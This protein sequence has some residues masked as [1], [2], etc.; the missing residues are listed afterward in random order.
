MKQDK[1]RKFLEELKVKVP[2]TQ[3]RSG[4]TV[5]ECPLG[6]WKH[7]GGKSSP[8][9]FGVK[10]EPGDPHANCFAC[11]FH[12]T[13][14]ELLTEAKHRNKAQ[15]RID[16]KW[17]LLF[18]MVDQAVLDGDLDL[19]TP[20]IEEVMS[21]RT[22]DLHEF[23]Q[24]W[25]DSF[26]PVHAIPWANTYLAERNVSPA[27]AELLDLRA[28]T[29][30]HRIC[31]PV[32]D[33]KHRLVGLHGRAV[34]A[35]V[36]PRYRMYLQA[37][38][39]NPIVWLGEDWVDL[40]RPIITVE[41]PFDL[42]SVKRVYDNVVSPLFVN[43][44]IAKLKR[45]S[46]ALEWITLYDRGAGGDAGREKVSKLLDSDHV[47]HHLHPPKGRKDPGEMNEQEIAN[48]IAPYVQLSANFP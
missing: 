16:V 46:D 4:W 41:G 9:V 45:M 11:G 35:G 17:G 27:M 3:R 12:G 26:P 33:F 18:E 8:E 32:R 39:N 15:P 23:P 1:V 38:Q 34:H 40:N 19:D 6:P 48:L 2:H 13:L 47:V 29:E 37:D 14:G 31:F 5:S 7:D 28:D 44:S 43:P 20:D 30:Q 36:E 22:E 25:L 24:W 21:R 42:A 10:D